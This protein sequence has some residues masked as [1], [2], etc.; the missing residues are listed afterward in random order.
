MSRSRKKVASFSYGSEKKDKRTNN[1][2][3]RRIN[4]VRLIKGKEPLVMKE[5]SD[6]WLM[7][8]DGLNHLL[9]DKDSENY[10]K[11]RRK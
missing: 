10:K 8:K 4:K 11:G 9:I 6:E 1:R 3:L 2:R 7:N 5:V